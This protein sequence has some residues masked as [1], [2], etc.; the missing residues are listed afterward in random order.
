MLKSLVLA[1]LAVSASCTSVA[2]AHDHHDNGY[3]YGRHDQ[4]NYTYRLDKSTDDDGDRPWQ[5]DDQNWKTREGDNC[6]KHTDCEDYYS[7][8]DGRDR[9]A[10][11]PEIDPAGAM[12][13]LTLLLGG[14]AV[15]LGR[16][17]ARAT[18]Y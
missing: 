6:R 15:M 16:R 18:G 8:K 14:L 7:K 3:R 17:H 2:F 5:H 12:G 1:T 10:A 9:P 13:A 11:A 4:L